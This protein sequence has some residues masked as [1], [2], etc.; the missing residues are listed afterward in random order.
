MATPCPQAGA[1]GFVVMAVNGNTPHSQ[2]PD[3]PP[4]CTRILA[5]LCVSVCHEPGAQPSL[6]TLASQPLQRPHQQ[7]A[8]PCL[9]RNN[10]SPSLTASSCPCR[11]NGL[12]AQ[13][14][15][16]ARGGG[17]R[18]INTNNHSFFTDSSLLRE[19]CWRQLEGAR[20]VAGSCRR[21]AAQTRPHS[22][23][24]AYGPYISPKRLRLVDP[25]AVV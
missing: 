12:H 3:H 24:F 18:C 5:R 11:I 6:T 25:K 23:I 15:G 17:N 10:R 22:Q 7:R 1:D 21:Q 13:G 9:H 8:M 16:G 4:T 2:S 19:Q 20:R 14:A